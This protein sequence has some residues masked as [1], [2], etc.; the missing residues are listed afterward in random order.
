[1]QHGVSITIPTVEEI[2]EGSV[3]HASALH[4]RDHGAGAGE[5]QQQKGNYVQRRGCQ[6]KGD[7]NTLTSLHA[8]PP[9]FCGCLPLGRPAGSAGGAEQGRVGVDLGEMKTN[10]HRD[11]A[12]GK[13]QV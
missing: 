8:H 12:K 13:F 6:A 1:M 10:Q 3:P 4:N 2:G 9:N 11:H 5:L 7:E